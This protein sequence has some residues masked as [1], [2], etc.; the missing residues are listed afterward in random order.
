MGFWDAVIGLAIISGV[1]SIFRARYG[2]S[3]DGCGKRVRELEPEND[4]LRDEVRSLKDR[5]Q[6]LE[7]IATENDKGMMLD[8]E[9][10]QLRRQPTK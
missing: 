4:R 8:R 2:V 1:V 5:I 7:R 6:V 3:D 9:I 10:E